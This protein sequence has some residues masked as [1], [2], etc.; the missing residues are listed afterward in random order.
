MWLVGVFTYVF[1]YSQQLTIH[2]LSRHI[3]CKI[4]PRL[5]NIANLGDENTLLERVSG[6]TVWFLDDHN[7]N[8]LLVGMFII[9][10]GLLSILAVGQGAPLMP[11]ITVSLTGQGIMTYL[12]C[13]YPMSPP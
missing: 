3:R 4:G 7:F 9:A 10:P 5:Q 6:R 1:L 2:S 11:L 8:F 13:R 12:F